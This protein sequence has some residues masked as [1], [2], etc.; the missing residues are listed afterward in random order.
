MHGTTRPNAAKETDVAVALT[1]PSSSVRS[2]DSS[3]I[4]VDDANRVLRHKDMRKKRGKGKEG[5]AATRQHEPLNFSFLSFFFQF[6]VRSDS[7][8]V[9]K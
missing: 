7:E 8:G 5:N 6:L 9:E 2:N 1:T 4:S 3:I